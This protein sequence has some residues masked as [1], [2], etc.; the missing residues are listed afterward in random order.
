MLSAGEAVP[1]QSSGGGGTDVGG[2]SPRRREDFLTLGETRLGI[3][4]SSKAKRATK[5]KRLY[6]GG[7]G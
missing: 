4:A 1:W 3:S 2:G 7:N 6:L 5:K